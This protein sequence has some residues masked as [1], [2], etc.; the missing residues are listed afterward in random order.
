MAD[1]G[2]TYFRAVALDYDGTLADGLVA[3]DTLAALAETRARGIRF[4]VVTG[5]I[6]GELR[7]VFPDVQD[8]VDAIVAEQ[9]GVLVTPLGVRRLVAPV[10]QAVSAQLR[11]RG[12]PPRAGV[13]CLRRFRRDR[14]IGGG[15]RARP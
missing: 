12:P 10:D 11:D 15:P 1:A 9:G 13:D 3:P 8:H 14:R 7:A 4:I 2:F 6:M 5:R